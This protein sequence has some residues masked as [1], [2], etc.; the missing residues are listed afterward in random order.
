MQKY[1]PEGEWMMAAF[2]GITEEQVNEVCKKANEQSKEN[3]VVPVNYNCPGQ[4][5]VTGNKS[6]IEAVEEFAKEIGIKIVRILKTSGPFHTE[7]LVEASNALRKDMEN[8]I[9]NKFETTVIKN[10]D[11]TEY[12]ETDDIKD[13][14]AKHIINPVKFTTSLQKM[15]DMG[16]DTFIEIGPGRTLS[17]FVKRMKGD[18]EVNILKIGRASCRERV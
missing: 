3:F 5:V 10:I 11:G 14:L 6:G 18:K 2:L 1:I 13:I 9:F 4:I 17:G 16:V 7:K 8:I 15:L 12:K